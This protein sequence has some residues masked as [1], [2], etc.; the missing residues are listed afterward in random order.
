MRRS[1][2]AGILMIALFTTTAAAQSNWVDQFLNRYKPPKVDPAAA[3]TPQVSDE[4]WRLMVTQGAL[5]LSIN[6][7]VRLMLASNLDVTV[8]RFSPLATQYL[9]QTMFRPFE[10]TLD[11]SA[12][13]SRNTTPSTSQLQAGQGTVPFSQLQHRYTIGYS[14]MLQAGTAVSVNLNVNRNSSNSLFSTFNPA[15]FNTITY[16]VT[17]P[18]LRNYGRK[19][20]TRPIRL[21]RNNVNLSEVDFELQMIDLVAA[22]QNLYWDLVYQ[23]ED[24]K[25]RKASL[26]L[27][28]KTL[29]DNKRQ[30]QIGTMARIEVVQAESEVA[31]REEQMVTTTYTADQIQDRVKKLITNLGDPALVLADLL[32]VNAPPPPSSEDTMP[33][34]AAIKYALESRPELRQLALQI[35]NS[36]IEVEYAK[37]QLLPTLLVG[38]SYTQNGV[39]GVQTN[40]A[41]LGGSEITSIIRGGLGDALGQLFGYNYTGYTV[42]FSLSIPLSNKSGQAQYSKALTDKQSIA[43]R[44]TRL[45]QQIALE[46]RNAS[47]QV[48]MNRARI[49]KSEK[50][51]ELATMQLEAEQKKFQLGTSQLRFVLQEQR[52]VTD[53]QTVRTSALVNYAKS[54]VD[55][56]RAVGRTLRK[57]NIE[58]EKQMQV[59]T[60]VQ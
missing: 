23:R 17:Q 15:Y 6:D 36:D 44:R 20:N 26:D 50:A 18:F 30:V 38:A 45:A 1:L 21:G 14:Q 13:V 34:D 16:S 46:V 58:I 35:Q 28:E 10:P 48:D 25:V 7:V 4:P 55:Y 32:P 31:Q 8:N 29:A 47:T 22:A 43:A 51:L 9:L 3:V 52:N 19:I 27:A 12:Q 40:R 56:D 37:N 59:A 5:P 24:I 54:L 60:L 42:G 57:N 2:T 33:L 39:G 41:G 49:Q 53:A 11:L